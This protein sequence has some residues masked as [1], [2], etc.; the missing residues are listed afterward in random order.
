MW[1]LDLRLLHTITQELHRIEEEKEVTG[2]LCLGELNTT[3]DVT[4]CYLTSPHMI[5]VN[6]ADHPYPPYVDLSFSIG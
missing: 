1:K 3:R 2:D 6:L 5:H 4:I